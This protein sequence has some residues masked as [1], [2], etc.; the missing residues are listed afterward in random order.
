MFKKSVKKIKVSLKFDKNNVR[1]LYMKQTDMCKIM[2]ILR[3]TLLRMRN[4]S[5]KSCRENQNTQ[6]MFTNFFFFF[7]NRAFYEIM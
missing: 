3:R 1:V 4:V 7:E 5:D 6:L 2:I